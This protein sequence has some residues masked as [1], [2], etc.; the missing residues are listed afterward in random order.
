[1]VTLEQVE[2]LCERANIS[3]EEAK[4]ALEE[5][6]GDILEVLSNLENKNRIQAPKEVAIIVQKK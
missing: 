5:T 3:Y 6:N 4:V 2:K 1:M